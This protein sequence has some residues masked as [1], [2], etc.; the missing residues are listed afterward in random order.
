MQIR[1]MRYTDAHMKTEFVNYAIS[2]L[3][4]FRLF[5]V[6]IDG[7]HFRKCECILSFWEALSQR[8]N[9]NAK[10]IIS[11]L[12]SKIDLV[13]IIFM[14]DKDLQKHLISRHDLIL[15]QLRQSNFRPVYLTSYMFYVL[16]LLCFSLTL[17][18]ITVK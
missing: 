15:Q 7:S 13:T 14:Q 6:R 9:K 5:G 10:L 18:C 2:I 17:F 16:N 12:A 8:N 4:V 11:S 1:K 3:I